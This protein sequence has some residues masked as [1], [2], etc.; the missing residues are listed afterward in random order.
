MRVFLH[1][2][3][4]ITAEIA[5]GADSDEESS[6][7][8]T[9][10]M[11]QAPMMNTMG[12]MAQPGMSYGPPPMGPPMGAP[13]NMMAGMPNPMMG[14]NQM[15]GPMMGNPMGGMGKIAFFFFFFLRFCLFQTCDIPLSSFKYK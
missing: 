9:S 15:P 3:L 2:Y 13:P 5:D 6:N 10:T 14:G 4:L 7:P 1:P 12:A 11:G 8:P